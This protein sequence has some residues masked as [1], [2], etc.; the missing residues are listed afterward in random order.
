MRGT[1]QAL[2]ALAR[3]ALRAPATVPPPLLPCS[4]WTVPPRHGA[5]RPKSP[6]SLPTGAPRARPPP[7][8]IPPLSC[9]R[10]Y[11]HLLRGAN[12]GLAQTRTERAPA[13]VPSLNV[14]TA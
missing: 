1:G 5:L 9:P 11:G 14:E 6:R 3:A 12:T 13:L 7:A 10:G 4:R 2:L 8:S